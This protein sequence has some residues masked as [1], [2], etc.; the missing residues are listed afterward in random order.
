MAQSVAE[1][2][3]DL[4]KLTHGEII[5]AL[6]LHQDGLTQTEIAHRLACHRSTICRLLADYAD[7]RELAKHKMQHG[8]LKLAERVI[9]EAD[10]EQSLEVLD[11]LEVAPKRQ[12]DTSRSGVQILIGMPGSPAGPDPLLVVNHNADYR[13]Q[14]HSESVTAQSLP[15][16]HRGADEAK[17]GGESDAS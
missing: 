12:T 13:T 8:A 7:T 17:A 5:L 11:R 16:P 4:S 9:A 2:N 6:R 3:T 14:T 15:A 1:R 10:V